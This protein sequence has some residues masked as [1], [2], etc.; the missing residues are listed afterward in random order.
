MLSKRRFH[1]IAVNYNNSEET[2]LYIE[3]IRL[4]NKGNCKIVII[5]NNSQKPDISKLEDFCRNIENI[6]L[7]KNDKNIGYFPALNIG[8][9]KIE[10]SDDDYVI[11]G[12]NDLS[13]Q[14]D[15][16]EKLDPIDLPDN[17]FVIAPNIIKLNKI[18]QNPHIIRNF[19]LI[20]KTYRRIYYSNYYISVILQLIYSKFKYI[21]GGS[22]RKAHDKI[23][24]ILMGY[25]ACYILTPNFFK[26][27]TN[28][29]APVFLMGE[30]GILANQVLRSG[31]VTLYHPD[32]VVNHMDHTS[33][34]RLPS[35]ALFKFSQI[36]YSYYIENCKYIR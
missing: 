31:G 33:I 17:I 34:G 8:L 30:E 35:K 7:I 11:I 25:G 1:F 9:N 27:Y 15:F 36:S 22:D 24:P 13:F 23:I 16:I 20:E 14:H 21:K 5:D 32:L 19:N 12:N 3:S 18:H 29:D 26:H 4:L 2:F 28:L 6:V 10:R